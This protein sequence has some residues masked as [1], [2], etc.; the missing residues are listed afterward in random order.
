MGFY[1][2]LDPAQIKNILIIENHAAFIGAKKALTLGI[3]I[4]KKDLD[5]IIYGQGKK[6]VS[7]FSFLEEL[8]PA[9]GTYY[10]KSL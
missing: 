5:T 9:A 3:N 7:S 4:F 1:W 2:S 10:F 6:I 8:L